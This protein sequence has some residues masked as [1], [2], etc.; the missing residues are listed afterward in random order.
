VIVSRRKPLEQ[1]GVEGQ[2]E[3]NSQ[4]TGGAN[5]PKIRGAKSRERNNNGR[6]K[7]RTA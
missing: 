2:G 3:T 5:D 4:I 1:T 6:R 7:D